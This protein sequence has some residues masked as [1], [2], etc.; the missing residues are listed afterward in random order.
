[1]PKKLRVFLCHASQDKPVVRELYRR[2]LA[3]N[4]IDP[5]LDEERLLPGQDWDL[6]IEKAV[7]ASDAVIVCLSNQSMTKEGY[8]QRELKF[9]LDIALEKPE[10]TIFVVPLRL[11]EC[12]L[13]RRLRALH[14][15]DYFPADHHKAANQRLLQSLQARY[16]QIGS[17]IRESQVDPAD[18]D[19]PHERVMSETPLTARQAPTPPVVSTY[20]AAGILSTIG[21]V[22]PII[23]LI[24]NALS[25]A[26][27][28][29]N[30]SQF[31]LGISAILAGF[32]FFIKREIVPGLP[33]KILLIIFLIAHSLV[34]YGNYS[35]ADFTVVPVIVESIAALAIAGLFIANF[36][37]PKKAAPFSTV[38]L[39]V[40]LLFIGSKL[41]LNLLGV[42]P[43]T[44]YPIIII[45]GIVAAVL[46]LLDL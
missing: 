15:V 36:R 17:D 31:I 22:L 7:E 43:D 30:T 20:Q 25:Y 26:G 39:A 37:S 45:T 28:D 10:G 5:W 35:G 40:F 4:W 18:T 33:F 34:S 32:F 14:Y 29:G 8:V 2:L 13:P 27:F 38:I 23:F 44:M 11:D 9:V 16:T 41:I 46:V 42:W 12:A 6:E 19:P 3:E 21:P 1:M 24:L